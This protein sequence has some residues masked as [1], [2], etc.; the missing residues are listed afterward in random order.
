M[1][2]KIIAQGSTKLDRMRKKWGL[3]V[4]VDGDLLFDTFCSAALLKDQCGKYGVEPGAI[5][6]IVISHEHWD[7]TGGLWWILENT[8]NIKVYACSRFSDGF[9]KK[10]KDYGGTLVEVTKTMSIKENIFS[11]GEIE[12][13]CN[14]MPVFEQSLILKQNDTLAVITGCS[15]PGILKI[16]SYIGLEYNVAIDLLAGGLHLMNAPKEEIAHITTVIDTIYRIK[17]I[18]PFHCTGKKAIKYFRRYMPQRLVNVNPGDYFS[19]NE[20]ISSW[21]FIKGSD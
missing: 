4:L 5:K 11:T 13:V 7:H 8:G 18:A 2:F 14:D 12:G 19:F 6:H 3:A 17:T 21:D 20:K 16:L 10:V 15:H 9:K 1:N